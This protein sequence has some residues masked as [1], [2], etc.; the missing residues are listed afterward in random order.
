[1]VG[2]VKDFLLIKHLDYYA[3]RP[4]GQKK[5]TAQVRRVLK[6]TGN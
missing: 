2:S 3:D 1:M 4:Y 5:N 6:D